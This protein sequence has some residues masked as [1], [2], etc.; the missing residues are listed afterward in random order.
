[1]SIATKS[2]TDEAII[3]SDTFTP[4][5]LIKSRPAITISFIYVIKVGKLVTT[6]TN[7][8]ILCSILFCFFPNIIVI[9]KYINAI[10]NNAPSINLNSV[11]LK[12]L[13]SPA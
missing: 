3:W 9:P 8:T 12:N 7:N 1:M 13:S 10:A 6:I 11:E 2:T 5:V 4:S